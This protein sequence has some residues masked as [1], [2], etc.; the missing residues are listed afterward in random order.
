MKKIF[1]ISAFFSLNSCVVNNL[2]QDFNYEEK[3]SKDLWVNSYKYEVFYGCIKEGLG[4]DSLRILLKDKDF[5]NKS[6]DLE[7]KTIDE[8]RKLGS[9]IV[10]N[11]PKPYIKLENKKD[12]NKN[13]ISYNC[14]KYY[15]SKE[16]DS[17]A[18]VEY[19]KELLNKLR[20]FDIKLLK[21][22]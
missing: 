21:K 18:N 20:E 14:L 11:M 9:S 10:I 16:L 2:N 4:N 7:F 3:N 5:F 1:L 12:L 22:Y 19:K 8:A 6:L 17:I 15:A 13:F